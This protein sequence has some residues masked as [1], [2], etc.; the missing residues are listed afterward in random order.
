MSILATGVVVAILVLALFLWI[1]WEGVAATAFLLLVVVTLGWA[2]LRTIFWK[3]TISDRRIFVRHGLLSVTEETARL[4]RVQ[5]ITLRQSIFDRLFGVGT[6]SI[7][8]AGTSGSALEFRGLVH[9]TD[10][11]ELL[12]DAVRDAGGEAL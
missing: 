7:D 8:T 5:D 12:E 9:P 2:L 11:R 1:G 3:Y 6:L 10:V 4:G